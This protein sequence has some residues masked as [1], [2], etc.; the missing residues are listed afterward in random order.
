MK[1]AEI[2]ERTNAELERLVDELYDDL[3][4]VRVKKAT[5]QL[6]DTSLARR[7]RRDIARIKTVLRARQLGVE[8]PPQ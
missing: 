6:D 5:N 1:V 8:K 7:L 4:K 2:R 3:Y